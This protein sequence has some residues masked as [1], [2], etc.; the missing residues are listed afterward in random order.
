MGDFQRA[1]PFFSALFSMSRPLLLGLLRLRSRGLE[2][3][4]RAGG[5][6]V[7]AN[8]ASNLDPLLLAIPLYPRQVRDMTNGEL[9]RNPVFR[10]IA[11][12]GGA[13]PVR[14]G[15]RDSEAFTAAVRYARHGRVAAMFPEGTRRAKGS[16]TNDVAHPRPGA[17]RIA[18]AAGVPLVPA[19]IAGTD[20]LSRLAPIRVAYG[21]RIETA[22]L[23]GRTRRET[24]HAAS[25]RVMEEIPRLEASL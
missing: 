17:A 1:S 16:R 13:F 24:A 25:E 4:R 3:V 19:A 14:R 15:E 22:S 2:H 18:L 6:V 20:G 5:F 7:A 11:E 21:P 8:H 12:K 23:D 10:W 9:Y